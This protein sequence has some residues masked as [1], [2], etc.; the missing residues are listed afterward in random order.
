MNSPD[1]GQVKQNLH[2]LKNSGVAKFVGRETALKKIHQK[3]QKTDRV[4]IS[5]LSGMGGIGK[6]ELALQYAWQEWKK[7]TY[8]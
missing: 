3:L 6:T 7:G 8:L 5:T 2:N 1:S 4:A